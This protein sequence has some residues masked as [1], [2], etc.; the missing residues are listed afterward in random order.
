[1][2]PYD[3]DPLFH[4]ILRKEVKISSKSQ[5]KDRLDLYLKINPLNITSYHM[6]RKVMRAPSLQNH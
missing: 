1:M 3:I 4:L 5:M 6:T 2:I